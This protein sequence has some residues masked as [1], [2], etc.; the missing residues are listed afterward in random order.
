MT[1]GPQLIPNRW[2][3]TPATFSSTLNL[4]W[5]PGGTKALYANRGSSFVGCGIHTSVIMTAL[6]TLLL[7]KLPL[8]SPI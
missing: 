2:N 4:Q 7:W 6:T 3:Q 5:D 1:L 8:V